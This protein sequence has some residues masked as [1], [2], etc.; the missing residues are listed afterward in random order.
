MEHITIQPSKVRG[1]GNVLNP[2]T[3]TDFG[4]YKSSLLQNPVEINGRSLTSFQLD[5]DPNY[6]VVDNVSLTV[7]KSEYL[8]DEK[9]LIHI[10]VVTADNRGIATAN[11]DLYIDNV[12]YDSYFADARGI[13]DCEYTCHNVGEFTFYVES[14]GI[15]SESVSI[16]V[17]RQ[18]TNITVED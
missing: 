10:N 6:D 17:D 5:Y 16:S 11:V 15:V 8:V 4:Y 12:L 1:L 13:V 18:N 7:D 3:P 14:N 2:K 9:V